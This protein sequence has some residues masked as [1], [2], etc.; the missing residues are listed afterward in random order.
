MKL[1]IQRP[2]VVSYDSDRAAFVLRLEVVAPVPRLVATTHLV[3]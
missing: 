2:N 3:F 1:N